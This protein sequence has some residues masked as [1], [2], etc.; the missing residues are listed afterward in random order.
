MTRAECQRCRELMDDWLNSELSVETT[1]EV[2]KHVESCGECRGELERRQVVRRLLQRRLDPPSSPKLRARVVAALAA[3]PRPK[4]QPAGAP[5]LRSRVIKQI[6]R[7]ETWGGLDLAWWRQGA[8][9]I[10]LT[11]M[12]IVVSLWLSREQRLSAAELLSRSG[13]VETGWLKEASVA[14]HRSFTLEERR[15]PAGTLVRKQRVEIW[16]NGQSR[17]TARRLFDDRERLV[18]A[19]WVGDDGATTVYRPGVT[20]AREFFGQNEV[21]NSRQRSLLAN[22][23]LWRMNVSANDFVAVTSAPEESAVAATSTEFEIKYESR[24]SQSE[25]LSRASLTLRRSDLHAIRETVVIADRDDIREYR[26]TERTFE[27][28]PVREV[29]PAMFE[30][31]SEL[32]ILPSTAL[33][34]ALLRLPRVPRNSD[35]AVP[36]IERDLGLEVDTLYALHRIGGDT[37]EMASVALDQGAMH[38]RAIVPTEQRRDEYLAAMSE[39]ADRSS[40]ELDI[41]VVPEPAVAPSTTRGSTIPAVDAVRRYF[42]D[43]MAR[44]LTA[45]QVTTATVADLIEDSTERMAMR[46]RERATSARLH[47]DALSALIE[48]FG[49]LTPTGL[50]LNAT[51]TWQTMIRDH[52]RAIGHETEALR[53]ELQPVFFATAVTPAVIV[54][55]DSAIPEELMLDVGRLRELTHA[56]ERAIRAS[57]ESPAISTTGLDGEAFWRS[58]LEAERIAREFDRPWNLGKEERD[59]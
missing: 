50:S 39:L 33:S 58:L 48:R 23:E 20:P 35:L 9:G 52:A 40:V 25:G 55:S 38:V 31:D 32:T 12:L 4:T 13:A 6:R 15:L 16:R 3:E 53:M 24:K 29:A 30:P 36:I 47:A 43:Y 56:H 17:I 42:T 22:R 18:A 14:V 59:R 5:D 28:A 26:I 21:G 37:R 45:E 57:F 54:R 41:E 44:R 10:A 8:V 7:S 1:Q 11:A 27:S 34:T 51:A 2:L 19:E 49:T 46:V